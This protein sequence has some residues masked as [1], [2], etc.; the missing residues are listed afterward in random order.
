MKT[1]LL[2]LLSVVASAQVTFTVAITGDVPVSITNSAESLVAATNMMLGTVGPGTSPTTLTASATST[3]TTFTVANTLGV[4][5]CMGI[6]TGSE[7]SLITGISGNVLTVTRHTIG[8]T[9]A[10][11]SSGQ[12]VSFTA[13]GE[14]TCYLA[15]LYQVGVPGRR[16]RGDD[17]NSWTR[18]HD[19]AN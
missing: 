1:I 12:A 11:Y 6:L 16:P 4:Q 8:T 19:P 5:T 2:F 7:L 17:G 10:A 14:G 9:P 13:W 18:C 15:F 3:Q